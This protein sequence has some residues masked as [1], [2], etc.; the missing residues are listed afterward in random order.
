MRGAEVRLARGSARP[1]SGDQPHLP[2][3][4]RTAAHAR[5]QPQVHDLDGIALGL[6][7]V[8]ALVF[9]AEG[10]GEP[11]DRLR[12]ARAGAER[13]REL[14]GLPLILEIGAP[15]DLHVAPVALDAQQRLRLAL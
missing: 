12:A 7:A 2:P 13:Y 10:L 4:L 14:V 1:R 8:G 15:L 9:L 3:R 11:A 6:V 5:G